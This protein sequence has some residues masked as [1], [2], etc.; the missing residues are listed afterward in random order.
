M[1]RQHKRICTQLE[2]KVPGNESVMHYTNR[3]AST[4]ASFASNRMVTDSSRM[5]GH[6]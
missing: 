4:I 3:N 5:H 6:C 2:K 1:P